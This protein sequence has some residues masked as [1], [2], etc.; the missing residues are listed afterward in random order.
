MKR[1]EIFKILIQNIGEVKRPLI[2]LFFLKV[3]QLFFEISPLLIYSFF[4]NYVL[5]DKNIYGMWVVVCGY[6]ITFL[7]TTIGIAYSKKFS[8]KL[9]LKFDLK[10]KNILLKKFI[11]LDVCRYSVGDVKSRIEDDTEV[12]ENFFIT[13]ILDYFYNIIYAI[14]LAVILLIYDW[15]IAFISFIFI[16]VALLVISIVGKKT[17]ETGE[18]LWKLQTEYESFLHYTFQN[19]KEIKIN[20]LEDIQYAAL[21]Q[22]LK[23][24][25][26]VYFSNQLSVHFG[27]TF[28][29][30]IKN[31]I[32]QLFIYFVGGVFVIMGYI[33]V[34]VLLAFIG[35]YGQFFGCVQNISDSLVNIKNDIVRIE[36]VIEILKLEVNEKPYK[37]IENADIVVEDLKFAYDEKRSF[38]LNDIS[39]SV[40]TGEHLAI[41][42]ES[43]SGKSTISKLLTGQMEPQKGK[44]RIGGI[45]IYTVSRECILEKV[46][47]VEQEPVFFNMTIREN[48]LMANKNLTDVQ[49]KEYCE[50][51][52]IYDFIISL[53]DKWNTVI[54]EKGVKLSG[55]QKQRLAIARALIQDRDILIFDE[56]TSALDSERERAVVTEIKKLSSRK[57]I[58]SIAHRLSSIMDCDKVMILKNGEIA[59][60]DTHSNLHNKNVEYDRLFQNQYIEM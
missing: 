26:P 57:T 18:K 39:F 16:P 55:G 43:G 23:D 11:N 38:A 5:V 10:I 48:L 21:D 42:G 41:V 8:N 35:F 47:I 45:D 22:Y 12:T 53:P 4:V 31:F 3:W 54:G 1:I 19:W 25:R 20:N 44:I 17:S 46:S 51:A 9:I 27:V 14:A 13:H 60:M 32:T 15:R 6:L 37:K 28:S 7:L 33:Q 49:L 56:S 34:G 2:V 52:G 30:F 50:Q 40:N 29:Y 59:A 24:I 58:I 36:K